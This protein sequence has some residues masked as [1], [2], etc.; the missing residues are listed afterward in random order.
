MT[1]LKGKKIAIV[2]HCGAGSIALAEPTVRERG[3]ILLNKGEIRVQRMSK[4]DLDLLDYV[5]YI[6]PMTRAECRAKSTRKKRRKF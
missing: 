4:D 6:V 3:I 5:P 1:E 2:G